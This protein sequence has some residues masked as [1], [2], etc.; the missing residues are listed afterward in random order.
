MV[1]NKVVVTSTRGKL[2]HGQREGALSP[3]LRTSA[4]LLALTFIRNSVE[5]LCLVCGSHKP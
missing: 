4:W 3:W 2:K 5:M 1:Q